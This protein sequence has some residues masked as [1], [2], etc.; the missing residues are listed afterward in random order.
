MDSFTLVTAFLIAVFGWEIWINFGLLDGQHVTMRRSDA[1]N[2][3]IPSQINW[4]T[5]SIVDTGVS[6]VLNYFS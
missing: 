6:S 2:C 5:N 1:L 4:L 3:A